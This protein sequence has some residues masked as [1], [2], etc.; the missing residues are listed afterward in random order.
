MIIVKRYFTT[1][2]F[3]LIILNGSGLAAKKDIA[4]DDTIIV[5]HSIAVAG[6]RTTREK[7]IIRELTFAT[8]D[9]LTKTELTERMKRSRQNLLNL[10]VFNFVTIESMDGPDGTAVLILVEER[11][12]L[13]PSLI[14]EQAD[15]NLSNLLHERNW[16]KVDYGLG[17][18]LDNFR[19]RNETLKFST[20][21]GYNKRFTLSHTNIYLDRLRRNSMEFS[22]SYLSNDQ[23]DYLVQN[24]KLLSYTSPEGQIVETFKATAGYAYR[25][26]LYQKHTV[27]LDF[28][29]CSISDTVAALNPGYLYHA[30][31][32]IQFMY[33]TYN[34][35]VDHR[36]SRYY[37]LEGFF[38]SGELRKY[39]LGLFNENKM[40]ILQFK[41]NYNRYFQLSRRWYF[42]S[43]NQILKSTLGRYPF[44]I[45]HGLGYGK[46][47]IRGYEYYVIDGDDYFFTKNTLKFNL[48]PMHI[49]HLN[50]IPFRKFNKI[51]YAIHLNLSADAGYVSDNTNDYRQYN[52]YMVNSL[53]YSTSAGIDLV[54]YY[55]S[56]FS[57]AYAIN[58]S[59]LRAFYFHFHSPL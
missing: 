17:L 8:G 27:Y 34:Y 46:N 3:L 40:N 21:L 49:T 36:D 26:H 42:G 31:T 25:K 56:V 59:G 38:Y 19:G 50:F 47:Y 53:L 52:N 43:N 44:Y 20:T 1:T 29:T 28:K 2:C 30:N 45:D 57:V 9:T 7:I 14:L 15:R 54:S 22:V 58:K 12:Y 24:N 37:P 32:A 11:W 13:W 23:V 39:G 10:S 51:H 6:N 55:D 48:L 16:S 33:L 5:I 4:T 41:A 18:Q 35:T